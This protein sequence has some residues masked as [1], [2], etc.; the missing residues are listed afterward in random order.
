MNENRKLLNQAKHEAMLT[1]WRD[2]VR[3]CRNS[4]LRVYDW[5]KQNG[6]ND[7]TYYKWQHE[8]QEKEDEKREIE[9]VNRGEIQFTEVPKIYLEQE[10]KE[11]CVII[12][13]NGW[14]IELQN[15]AKPELVSQIIQAVARYV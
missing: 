12:Q 13:K 9:S 3:E 2:R 11:P 7:K 15:N 5:C 10:K 6:I 4:G 1:I 8:I 14:E